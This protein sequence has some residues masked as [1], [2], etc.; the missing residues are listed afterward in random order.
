MKLQKE[1]EGKTE[2]VLGV[3]NIKMDWYGLRM[4]CQSGGQQSRM[5]SHGRPRP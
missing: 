2:V 3:G 4:L 5:E 1:T